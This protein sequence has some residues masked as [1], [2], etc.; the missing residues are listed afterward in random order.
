[1]PFP[2]GESPMRTFARY[3]VAFTLAVPFAGSAVAAPKKKPAPARAVA[4]PQASAKEIDKLKGEFKWGMSPDEVMTKMVQKIEG[5]FEERLKKTATDPARQD[6]VRKEMRAET[7]KARKHSLVKFEGQKSGYDVSII[8]QEFGHNVGESMLVAKEDNASRYFFF[9]SDRLYKMFVAFDKDM[10]EGKTFKDFGQLM[11]ARFGKAKEI[12]IDERTKSGVNHKLDHYIWSTKAGDVLRLVDRS[13]FYD[14]YCLVIYDGNVAQQQMASY[15]AHKKA[16]RA[17][18][19]VDAIVTKPL[20]NRDENDNVIDRITGREV[21]RPGDD[22]PKDIV[23]PMP[24]NVKAPSPSEVNR[25]EAANP[26]D[27]ETK[28]PASKKGK[29]KDKPQEN[30]PPAGLEL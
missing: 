13:A 28:A 27:E 11:Q 5:T 22:A 26:P 2:R 14:V 7:E 10:L 20:N 15:K 24:Q 4:A 3:L 12:F 1:M 18:A 16:D 25:S 21:R 30:K 17:D 8:D 29:G 19:L 6:R 9:V 23:V